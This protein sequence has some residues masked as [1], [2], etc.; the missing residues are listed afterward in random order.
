MGNKIVVR[1]VFWV[2]LF[3]AFSLASNADE[4]TILRMSPEQR[5]GLLSY[6]DKNMCSCGCGMKI[7]QCL[8]EDPQCGVSPEMAR[9]AITAFSSMEASGA[10]D[11]QSQP[12]ASDH[13]HES[14]NQSQNGSVVSG[15][16]N[17]QDCTFAS[18]GGTTVKL[19]D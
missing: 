16:L 18:V 5:D 19:C 3:N 17:G 6:L 12:S 10:E 15:K 9:E 2:L 1:C 4:L 13:R 14:I 8:H 11:L 7:G